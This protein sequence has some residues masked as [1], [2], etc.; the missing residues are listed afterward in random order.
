[1][2]KTTNKR[3]AEVISLPSF[4]FR[5]LSFIDCLQMCANTREFIKKS[6]TFVQ[7]TIC[8]TI[9]CEK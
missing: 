9:E 5:L 8:Y 2:L 6:D 3:M 4:C 7:S 1:M